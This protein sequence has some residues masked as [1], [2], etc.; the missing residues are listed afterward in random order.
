[1]Q[2]I[3]TAI[4]VLLLVALL[5]FSGANWEGVKVVLWPNTDPA[6]TIVADTKIPVLV[7]ISFLT[8]FLPMWLYHQSSKWKTNR[9]IAS[10]EHALRTATAPP[11]PQDE[12]VENR[13][14]DAAD[15]PLDPTGGDAPATDSPPTDPDTGP[16]RA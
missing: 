3:R 15:S 8:G 1:M 9:R 4:W 2:I 16:Q 7:I 14:A 6:K 11:L 13:A 12:V 10:L 5:L